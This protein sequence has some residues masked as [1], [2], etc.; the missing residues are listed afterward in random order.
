MEKKVQIKTPDKKIIYGV[1]RGSLKKPL[2][3]QVHGLTGN[4]NSAIHYNAARYFEKAG[5]SDFRFNLYDWQKGA[6]KLHE[7]TL[8]THG[9]DIDTVIKYFAS[10][11]VKKILLVGHSY[12]FPSIL[13]AKD[14]KF[15]T[16]VSWDGSR[17]PHT[18]F[19]KVKYIKNPKG[20][21]YAGECLV[22]VGDRMI[23]EAHMLNSEKILKTFDKPIKFITV[24]DKHE[25]NLIPTKKMYRVANEPK[26]LTIIKGG[27]H[28]FWEDGKQEV[29]YKET[30]SWFK[31]FL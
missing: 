26:E 31:K 18:F 12:G 6:R 16:V 7:C 4:M 27:S 3:I 30:V 20:A 29:L 15:A 9:Q 5:F 23:K 19:D 2:I 14:R 24:H 1:L 21:L 25:G 11:G 28:T 22:F 8:K 13:C 17:L 10:R